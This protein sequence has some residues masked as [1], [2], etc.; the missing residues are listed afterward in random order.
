[1]ELLYDCV[2][3][4]G[5]KI[6]GGVDYEIGFQV[7]DVFSGK[8]CLM[9]YVGNFV[10]GIDVID[11]GV[12]DS[13]LFVQVVDYFYGGGVQCDY[14]FGIGNFDGDVVCFFNLGSRSG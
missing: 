11:I 7:Y 1:M 8:L 9:F 3:F 6:V 13:F 2:V 4:F 14:V 5:S 10:E 12:D